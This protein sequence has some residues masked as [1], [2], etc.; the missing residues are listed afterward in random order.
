MYSEELYTQYFEG[1]AASLNDLNHTDAKP[2]FF[3]NNET[4]NGFDELSKAIGGKL[5]LPCLA[6]DEEEI[7]SDGSSS[8]QKVNIIGGFAIL[9]KVDP[10]DIKSFRIARN[11]T[12]RIARKIINK[13]KRDSRQS[14]DD[15]SPLLAANAIQLGEIRQY[16]TP[17][18]LKTLAGWAVEFKWLVPEDISFGAEDFT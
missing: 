6:L 2:H 15:E 5:Q 8:G 9:D 14:F 4:G 17:V 3:M 7:D 13:M 11:K 10:G 16:P 12:K 18:I 1:L